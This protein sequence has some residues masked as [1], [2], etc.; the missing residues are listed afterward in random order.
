[1]FETVQLFPILFNVCLAM[2]LVLVGPRDKVK[3]LSVG[4]I[5]SGIRDHDGVHVDDTY[6]GQVVVLY[7]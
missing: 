1:M 7:G 3:I 2:S 4:F 5:F 6:R